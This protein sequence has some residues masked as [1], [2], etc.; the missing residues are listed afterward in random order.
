M[1][2]RGLRQYM[3]QAGP[4]STNLPK[5]ILFVQGGGEG[6]HDHWD[7][8]LVDSLARELGD[9][10]DIHYPR[11]PNEEDPQYATWR[12]T[13]FHEIDALEDGAIVVGHSIGGTVLIHALTERLPKVQLKGIFL[14]AVPF[15]GAG[16]WSSDDIEPRAQFSECAPIFLYHGVQDETAPVAHVQLYAKTMAHAVVRIIGSGDHQLNNDL[17]VVAADIRSIS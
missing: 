17:R 15:I 9:A 6:V 5:P 13:L 12:D 3:E 8:K 14:I 10:Y 16:G 2:L 4:G 7:N 1:R 11:M